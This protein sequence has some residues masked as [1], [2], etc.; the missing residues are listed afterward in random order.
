VE[1]RK[2]CR[3]LDNAERV[4]M[5]KSCHKK[6]KLIS[7][8]NEIKAIYLIKPR[9]FAPD[10][11]Y[12][13]IVRGSDICFC[14][15]GGQFYNIRHSEAEYNKNMSDMVFSRDRKN[16][17]HSVSEVTSL[18]IRK[19]RSLW[20]GKIPNNG[21]VTILL[22]TKKEKYIIHSIQTAAAVND[23]FSSIPGLVI[24]FDA[25]GEDKSDIYRSAAYK[26]DPEYKKVAQIQST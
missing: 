26:K 1:G 18:K 14:R 12:K 5:A 25:T 11:V 9:G 20:T 24:E 10:I 21:I 17:S 15:V 7:K 16:F 3:K 19:R 4:T 8:K 6:Y 22:G 2:L 23:F 13:V